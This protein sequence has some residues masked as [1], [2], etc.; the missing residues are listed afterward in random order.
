MQT[1]L[2]GVYVSVLCLC[3]VRRDNEILTGNNIKIII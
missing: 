1:F 3:V 2:K